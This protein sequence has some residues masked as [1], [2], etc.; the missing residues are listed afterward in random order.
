MRTLSASMLVSSPKPVSTGWSSHLMEPIP[1]SPVGT[2]FDSLH[3]ARP[4]MT[5]SSRSSGEMTDA[6]LESMKFAENPNLH[7]LRPLPPQ[8]RSFL[9][10]S[11]SSSASQFS[12]TSGFT[13][14]VR[15][16]SYAMAPPTTPDRPSSKHS[17]LRLNSSPASV[18]SPSRSAMLAPPVSLP[19]TPTPPRSTGPCGL[20]PTPTTPLSMASSSMDPSEE[21]Y[22]GPS[23]PLP[24]LSEAKSCSKGSTMESGGESVSGGGTGK[25]SWRKRKISRSA[26]KGL[27]SAVKSPGTSS[28]LGGTVK[29]TTV[30]NGVSGGT[31]GREVEEVVGQE[32]CLMG[33]LG[34]A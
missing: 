30:V 25:L 16:S 1:A 4:T 27:G 18:R 17:F 31:S 2:R 33:L 12:S 14:P 24:I 3:T 21:G 6:S 29:E 28:S 11:M 10:P 20:P 32:G 23:S 26:I 5:S 34:A 15:T 22:Y 7:H 13:T 19:R 8:T 9:F